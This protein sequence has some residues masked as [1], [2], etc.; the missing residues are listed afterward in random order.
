ESTELDKGLIEKIVDPLTHLVRNAV[1]H[2]LEATADRKASGKSAVGHITL[3][4]AH[5]SGQILIEIS[6]DG[7]GLNRDRIL[8]KAAKQGMSINPDVSDGEVWDLIFAPGFSTAEEVTDVSGRGV[9][10]DVVRKNIHALGGSVHL[11]SATGQG[12]RVSI[13]LP[14]T[15]AI[16]DGMSVRAGDET[17]IVPLGF[18]IESLHGEALEFRS[19]GRNGQVVRIRDD[20]LPVVSLAELFDIP[21]ASRGVEQA[22]LVVLEAENG[23]IALGVDALLGQH[24]VVVKNLETNYRRVGGISGATILGDG[25][26]SLILDVGG[27]IR[28][29][30]PDGKSASA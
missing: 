29:A 5:Q 9:G 24:Q 26:V 3:S 12:T 8:A 10:M 7:A 18:V 15:L 30:H 22:V 21:G 28:M 27:L 16:L 14:L 4:A 1:D 20:Y 6:D 25:Q 11:S 19:I 17:F 23:R 2:G 13:R